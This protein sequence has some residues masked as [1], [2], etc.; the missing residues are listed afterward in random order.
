MSTTI[1]PDGICADEEEGGVWLADPIGRRAVRVL[2]GGAVTDV[3]EFDEMPVACVLAG[4]DR[5]T[6]VVC[7]APDWHREAALRAPLA[8][9]EAFEVSVAGTG[10]P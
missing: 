2:D 7:V 8:H 1:A 10:T 5:R 9:L 6:L 3:L 4:A